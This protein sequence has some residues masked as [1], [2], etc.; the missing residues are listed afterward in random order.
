[1]SIS[2][3]K[4]NWQDL[5]TK[6]TP[7]SAANLNKIENGIAD[8]VN[9]VNS[10]SH[11]I[12]ELQTRISQMSGGVPPTASS[13]SG[14]NPEVSPIYVNTTDGKWYYWDGTAF[15]PGGTYGGATTSTTFNQHGVPADD[16]AV[17]DA[18]AEK[19]DSSDV[20]ALDTRVTAVEG[21]LE[22]KADTDDVTATNG[23]VNDLEADL[24]NI[25]DVL[26]IAENLFD[27]TTF[28]ISNTSNWAIL[29][30]TKT[31][32]SVENLR[33]FSTGSPLAPLNLP[34]GQYVF[35]ADF[36]NSAINFM[37]LRKNNAYSKGLYDGT[38]FDISEN[39]VFEISFVTGEIGT[40]TITDISIKNASITENAIEA[41]ENAD[42]EQEAEINNISDDFDIYVKAN[43][44]VKTIEIEFTH[45]TDKVINKTTGALDAAGSAAFCVSEMVP[46]SSNNKYLLNATMRFNNP[47]VAF[48][49]V[50]GAYLSYIGATEGESI[51]TNTYQ[52]T[53][54]EFI[55]P[56]AVA[57]MRIGFVPTTGSE[58]YIYSVKKIDGYDLLGVEKK[59][60]NKKWVCVGD[61]LTAVNSRTTKH[62]FDYV[63]EKTGIATVNMGVS[64][65][66]YGRQRENDKA[67]YQRIS[68]C[69]TD[70][71]VV[72][73]F[74]SFNDLG[75]GLPIG[76]VDDTGTDTLAGCINT[77]ITNLQSVIP[78]VNLGI[79]APTPWDTTQ[80]PATAPSAGQLNA[81]NYVEMLK[82]ICARRSIPFLD[83][84]RESNLRPWDADFRALAYSKDGGSGTHPDENGHKLIAP[85]FEGLLETLLM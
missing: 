16:F 72:T 22:S 23:R 73:I 5:P 15:Q 69:P 42:A 34:S 11:S 10:N 59:W 2:Y 85:R 84:W 50:Q 26:N 25:N 48:Y 64:G 54:Y 17:G 51:D 53:D 14:M 74:G 41:L 3:T 62:Y 8:S 46:V 18:L 79:V 61:S 52:F 24:S 36:A 28:E 76:S 32:L 63:A 13:T 47:V 31:T 66:G 20:T 56:D 7:L 82:S 81:Y 27:A 70:A 71:D 38:I 39:D 83:L 75:A 6:T 58:R 57:Q 44:A 80:P 19:A 30:K 45:E 68:A 55:I 4:T 60:K 12:A 37:S 9:G 40:Y 49:D 43:S 77:T 78:L 29:E 1:M 65:T 21:A 33:G 67:F 35:H